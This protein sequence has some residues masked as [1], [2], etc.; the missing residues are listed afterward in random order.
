MIHRSAI[1]YPET[2]TVVPTVNRGD[3]SFVLLNILSREAGDMR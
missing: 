3:K 1:L 2:V